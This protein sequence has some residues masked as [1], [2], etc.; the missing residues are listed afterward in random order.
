[1]I[2]LCGRRMPY[3]KN[4][5]VCFMRGY[6]FAKAANIIHQPETK[7]NWTVV[8]VMGLGS[9]VRIV[10]EDMF[11]KMEVRYQTPQSACD[12]QYTCLLASMGL[13]STYDELRRKRCLQRI[14]NL[15]RILADASF[16]CPYRLEGL[17]E[18]LLSAVSVRGPRIRVAREAYPNVFARLPPVRRGRIAVR[19]RGVVRTGAARGTQAQG[20]LLMCW[21]QI[22]LEGG[23]LEC[24]VRPSIPS[25]DGGH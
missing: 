15:V 22:R 18:T 17:A 1:M 3:F 12:C 10:L 4:G 9:A 21:K 19:V 16:P 2:S 11:V 5:I 23:E 14:C 7:A 20:L 24:G 6:R 8:R 13:I 25:V